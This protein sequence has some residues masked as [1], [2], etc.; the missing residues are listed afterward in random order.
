MNFFSRIFNS[1]FNYQT[2]KSKNV[3]SKQDNSSEIKQPDGFVLIT[4]LYNETNSLRANE[5]L[6]CLETNVSNSLIE[7]VLVLYDTSR[8]DTQN[9]MLATISSIK[10]VTLYMIP[11]R[12]TFSEIFSI[13]ARDFHGKKVIVANS[14]IW[15]DE[16]LAM[17]DFNRFPEAFYVLS[18]YNDSGSQRNF[19]PITNSVELPNF[20]SADAWI[21][22]SPLNDSFYGEY[23]LGTMYSDSFLNTQLLKSKIKVL[24]PCLDVK[25][26]HLQMG[27]SESQGID[28]AKS[29]KFES[30]YHAEKKRAK[31]HELSSGVHWCF[32]PD[33]EEKLTFNY[34]VS[35]S[36][37]NIV[38]DLTEYS[39]AKVQDIIGLLNQFS[40]A[41][42][43]SVWIYTN[44]IRLLSNFVFPVR[45]DFLNLTTFFNPNRF[46]EPS[47]ANHFPAVLKTHSNI[48][49]NQGMVEP[50]SALVRT[51]LQ[52][53]K[54]IADFEDI[55][56]IKPKV[57]IHVQFGLSNRL[58]AIASA[59]IIAR[60]LG[61][62]LVVI[63]EPDVH[64]DCRFD[65][66][67]VNHCL[68]VEDSFNYSLEHMD[69]YNYM[70][71]PLRREGKLRINLN[72]DKVIYVKSAYTLDYKL[73]NKDEEDKFLRSLQVVDG[74]METVNRFD[75][76]DMIG[77]HVRM[78]GGVNYDTDL[79]DSDKYLDAKGKEL[80]NYWREKS[81]F[82]TFLP[83]V[84]KILEKNPDQ[85]FY[86]AADMQLIYDVFIEKFGDKITYFPRNVY[87]RSLE[88]Q[89]TALIDLYCLSR[90]RMIYGSNWS[91]F[92]EVAARLG[93]REVKLSGVHF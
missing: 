17:I 2:G 52:L 72:T 64:C 30:I 4:S 15:F 33:S 63:W 28:Q 11:G 70:N 9:Q 51:N 26:Y 36:R 47:T 19:L 23:E 21:F 58:R 66:L 75:L 31:E 78:G 32:L 77:L 93:N 18:R 88:Q 13:A 43:I 54:S 83:L 6:Y 34:K 20:L 46:F 53:K 22:K 92:S 81:H 65:D 55:A 76:T 25:A 60:D 27:V 16:S 49:I 8:N 85:K 44:D 86:L 91:S 45:S 24:N 41:Y 37:Q 80:M 62:K 67:F 3:K 29:K 48:L 59:Y 50:F 7:K 1:I 57:Y 82:K 69:C 71:G 42:S 87:D 10:N 68:Y 89:Y 79:W 14:D 5:L 56:L 12:P 35:W 74:I 61:R 73:Y 38:V 84:E 39:G 40:K 90:T